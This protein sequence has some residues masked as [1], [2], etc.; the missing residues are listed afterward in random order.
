MRKIQLGT[1]G[2]EVL[3]LGL[4]GIP[5]QRI[6]EKQAIDLIGDCL[7]MGINFIDTARGYTVSEGFIGNALKELGNP[8]IYLATK[9]MQ[10]S[11]VGIKEEMEM[12]F[13][14]LKRDKIDLY[15]FH[16]VRS[17][18]EFD[19]LTG[20]GGGY[21]Y[22]KKVQNEGRIAHLG[23]STH[24]VDILERAI[25][26]G[27]FATV[28]F[29]MNYMESQGEALLRRAKEKGIGTI[30]M[31][32]FAGGALRHK[33]LALRY[34]LHGGVGDVIIPGIDGPQQLRMNLEQMQLG[35][36]STQERQL[37]KEEADELGEH[38]CRRCGYCMPCSLGIDIPTVFLMEGYYSRYHLE[39]W[40]LERYGA[41]DKKAADCIACGLCES[42]CPYDL[43]IISM[44]ENTKKVLDEKLPLKF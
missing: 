28:Q 24:R 26:S 16:N 25:E 3:P 13:S 12:S 8:D 9:S 42:R 21:D 30:I 23:L 7:E 29:P 35:P 38:F 36:L 19:I 15:Q 41:F 27:L 6:E 33:D 43:P 5:L 14:L 4:G 40:A 20:P 22:C 44:M 34:L 32:P 2:M 10:R 17:F 39:E 31:K 37:I 18:E 11:E 1:T